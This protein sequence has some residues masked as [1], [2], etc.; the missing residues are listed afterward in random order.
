MPGDSPSPGNLVGGKQ[1][2]LL[3]VIDD[4]LHKNGPTRMIIDSNTHGCVN[5]DP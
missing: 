2:M 3:G 5:P 4:M 1:Y